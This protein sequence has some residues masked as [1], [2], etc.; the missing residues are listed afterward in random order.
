MLKID[1]VPIRGIL[2]IRLIGRLDRKNVSMLNKEVTYLLKKAKIKNV[3][4]NIKKLSYIDYYGKKAIINSFRICHF[5]RGN[6]FLCLNNKQKELFDVKDFK[7]LNIIKD[8]FL[9]FDLINL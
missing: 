3:V 9:A 2:C 1:I 7:Y 5:N 6:V 8:E 4:L